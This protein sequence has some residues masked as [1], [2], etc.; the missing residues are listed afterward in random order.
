MSQQHAGSPAPLLPAVKCDECRIGIARDFYGNGLTGREKRNHV[1][2]FML[3]KVTLHLCK[4][5]FEPID[6][7]LGQERLVMASELDRGNSNMRKKS[8]GT[9][10]ISVAGKAGRRSVLNRWTHYQLEHLT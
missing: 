10:L 4:A 6:K 1:R 3:C 8:Q 2:L 5:Y 7:L 9:H